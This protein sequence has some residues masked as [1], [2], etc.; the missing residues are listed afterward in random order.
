MGVAAELKL[1]K[2]MAEIRDRW[3]TEA[4]R[5]QGALENAHGI[6]LDAKFAARNEKS[7]EGQATAAALDELKAA[8]AFNDFLDTDRQYWAKGNEIDGQLKTRGDSLSPFQR[9]QLETSRDQQWALAGE[10][11]QFKTQHQLRPV[12]LPPVNTPGETHFVDGSKALRDT[13][14]GQ[15]AAAKE[16]AREGLKGASEGSRDLLLNGPLSRDQNRQLCESLLDSGV[17]R[18]G[19]KLMPAP[20]GGPGAKFFDKARGKALDIG[21]PVGVTCEGLYPARSSRGDVLG[22]ASPNIGDRD[23]NTPTSRFEQQLGPQLLA[24]GWS[25][26]GLQ[27]LSQAVQCRVDQHAHLGEAEHFLLS[28]DDQRIVVKHQFE[29]MQDFSI[30]EALNPNAQTSTAAQSYA[31]AVTVDGPALSGMAAAETGW[32]RA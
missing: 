7:L 20:G 11:Q 26:E 29:P 24:Q 6:H 31:S 2:N 3:A 18:L 19:S 28:T 9:H 4:E 25:P 8:K 14:A 10:F 23:E 1:P 32:E 30:E 12:H 27:T 13:P 21:D 22:A 17:S 5:F 16:W 15:W